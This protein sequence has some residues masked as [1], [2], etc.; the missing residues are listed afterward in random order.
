MGP[1][2]RR[3]VKPAAA[4]TYKAPERCHAGEKPSKARGTGRSALDMAARKKQKAEQNRD[5]CAEPKAQ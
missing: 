1:H 2:V 3:S 4:M 5:A